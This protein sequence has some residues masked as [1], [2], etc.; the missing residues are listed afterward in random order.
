MSFTINLSKR[1]FLFEPYVE[2]STYPV[3]STVYPIICSWMNFL[4]P[5]RCLHKW[6]Q[7]WD[8]GSRTTFGS[9]PWRSR[10][11]HELAAKLCPANNFV[12]WSPTLKQ[13]HINNYHIETLCREQNLGR[14]LKG[15]GHNMTLQQ[16]TCPAHNFVEHHIEMMCPYIAHCLALCVLY[17]IILISVT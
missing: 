15:Q 11:Q 12:I 2:L 7:Y 10:S 4:L 16:K 6:S 3:I 8:D 9:I 5:Y 13:F 1:I 17:C 14:Y